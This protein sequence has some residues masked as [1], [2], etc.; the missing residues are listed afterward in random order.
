MTVAYKPIEDYGVIGDLS[1]IALVGD[2]GSIDYMCLPHFDSPSIF[3]ALLDDKKGGRFSITPAI[4]GARRKQ[5]YLPDTNILLTRF[6]SDD[7]VGEIT[8][9]MVIDDDDRTQAIVRRVKGIR[10]PFS[11]HLRCA[12]RFDY[13]RA[14]HKVE[15][16]DDEILFVAEDEDDTKLRLRTPVPLTV[17]GGDAVGEF[18]LGSGETVD[19]ILEIALPDD[20]NASAAPGFVDNAFLHTLQYWRSWVGHSQYQG[21]W[22]EMVSRSALTLKLLTSEPCGS[23]AA[24]GTF[25][26]PEQVGGQRNWDYRYTWIRD[27]A[28][29]IATLIRLGF[30]E[31]ARAFVKWIYDRYVDA[32]V[33]GILQIM[34]GIDG[35]KE[36][37]EE[38]LDH[39]EGY[40]GSSPIRVGNAAFGQLQLDIYG[41][42]LHML[43]LHDEHVEPLSY[44]LWRHV[45]ESLNWVCKNWDRPDE[46][47]WEIRGGQQEFLYSRLMSWVA[48]DRG[49]RIA[50]R[51]SLPAP[52]ERWLKTRDQ[53][54]SDIYH[55]F[56]NEE[57]NGFV[58]YKGSKTLDSSALLAPLIGFIASR[59]QRWL[60][61]MDAIERELVSDA[62]VLRYLTET[63]A[64]DG[65]TGTEGTFCMCSYWY[66]ECVARAGELEKARLLF[67]KMHGYANHLGLYAEEMDPTG[68][69]L[70]NFPQAFTHW[71][72]IHAALFLHDALEDAER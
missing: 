19:F 13:A 57:R 62:L 43:D 58:Q 69:Y 29:S 31:E 5:M 46:G 16:R 37:P 18:T 44:D 51:H 66:I 35:R 68:S 45:A 4:K 49:I 36:L 67:E 9:F 8:D 7:G 70:G 6:L 22:R 21:R 50:T 25:G 54:H 42:L 65:L 30:T 63:A 23:I 59:D 17:E 10:G 3:V 27:G 40:R 55:E 61:T 47:I 14:H 56:W 28:F 32:E 41:E 72:L 34:Y 11:F 33:P 15:Q 20:E 53:I 38:T 60:A 71:G 24:A 52:V 2:D 39:L 12:P 26:L 64:A 48:L 1:T